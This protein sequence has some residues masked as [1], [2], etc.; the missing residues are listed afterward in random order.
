MQPNPQTTLSPYTRIGGDAAIRKLVE[1]FYEL[2]DE[3]PE[4]YAARKI[5]PGDLTESANKLFDFLSGWMGGPQRYIEKHG[6]PMLRRRHFPYAIGPEERD[7]WLLCMKLALEET[8]A[9]ASL[10]ANLFEQFSQLGEHM[11]NRGGDT[12]ACIQVD[13]MDQR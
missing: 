1:R 2:M 9:D 6:H 8:V 5:H 7:Q 11:R 12:H 13:A 10:R 4:A 3:L